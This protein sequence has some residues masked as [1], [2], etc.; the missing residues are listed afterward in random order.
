MIAKEID[1]DHILVSTCWRILRDCRVH[2]C[3]TEHRL[4][5]ATL[6]LHVKFIK[7]SRCDNNVF[8]FEKLKDSTCAHEYAVIVLNRFEVL[9]AQGQPSNRMA[10]N[11]SVTGDGW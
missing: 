6:K 2:R 11:Y 4:V 9:L 8:N 1:I 5:I 3:A 10:S 7:I